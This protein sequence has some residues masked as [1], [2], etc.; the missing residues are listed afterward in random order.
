MSFV[1]GADADWSEPVRE[2]TEYLTDI[3]TSHN[4]NE[5][6]IQLR[7]TPRTILSYRC[8]TASP[9]D[10]AALAAQ[11]YDQQG[12][13]MGVPLWPDAQ[14]L[15]TDAQIGDDVIDVDTTDRRFTVG[16][17]VLLWS[18]QNTHEYAEIA[19]VNAGSLELAASLVAEWAAAETI[20]VPLLQG[21]LRDSLPVTNPASKVST[22]NV[23]FECDTPALGAGVADVGAPPP[24]YEEQPPCIEPENDVVQFAYDGSLLLENLEATFANPHV[25]GRVLLV[26]YRGDVTPDISDEAGN[27]WI[28]L[29]NIH[30][31]GPSHDYFAGYYA[32]ANDFEDANT[33]RADR[34]GFVF[35]H[36][37]IHC[38]EL[39]QTAAPSFVDTDYS[40]GVPSG[41]IEIDDG[42]EFFSLGVSPTNWQVAML[43][44]GFLHMVFVNLTG[45]WNNAEHPEDWSLVKPGTWAASYY[46]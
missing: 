43:V 18:D 44:F 34:D 39:F 16:G 9:R 41:L 31:G 35:T 27:T 46:K 25:E 20:V 6:R 15:L 5:Q 23:V 14:P 19:A 30:Y 13:T 1:F 24:D 26:L 3:L 45:T 8:L 42:V 29:F 22:L 7:D 10:T 17:L 32:I 37:E 38:F 40:A 33:I 11:I 2:R 21:R 28:E 12:Q 36:M 4:Q